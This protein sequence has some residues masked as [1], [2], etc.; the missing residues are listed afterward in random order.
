MSWIKKCGA[1]EKTEN[2][3]IDM[4]VSSVD[5][6]RTDG[7]SGTCQLAKPSYPDVKPLASAVRPVGGRTL[8]PTI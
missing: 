1:G 5:F 3:R 7:R 2:L 4:L 8:R 6:I